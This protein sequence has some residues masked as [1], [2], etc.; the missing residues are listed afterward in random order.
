MPQKES[1]GFGK[2]KEYPVALTPEV[3]RDKMLQ[4][5]ANLQQ[6]ERDSVGRDWILRPVNHTDPIK[7]I[8]VSDLHIGSLAT[9]NDSVLRLVD[10]V[11]SNKNVRVVL[12]GDE[13]EGI[14]AEYLDTNRTPLDLESQIDLLR[15][16]CLEPLAEAGRI[17]AMVSGYW[18]HPGWAQDATT[19]NIW[20]TMTKGLNIPILKNGGEMRYKFA[21]GHIHSIRIR[22]NPPGGNRVDPVSGL[23]M[24]E[25]A[26]SES[27]RTDGAMSGH[28]HTMA[29]AKEWYFGAKASVYYISAGT[30]KGSHEGT[31]ADRYG[32]KLGGKPLCDPLGQGVI[33][34]G[35][36]GKYNSRI[37]Q[38]DKRD[39]PYPSAKHGQV[40]FEAINLLNAAEKQ[41]ITDEMKEKIRAEVEKA[42]KKTYSPETSRLSKTLFEQK[43]AATEKFGKKIVENQY[44]R[45]KM[46]APFDSLTFNIQ[47]KLP[48]TFHLD[49]NARIGSSDDAEIIKRL[50]DHMRLIR[51]NPHSFVVFLRNMI[52][53]EAGKSPERIKILDNFV[54]IINGAREQTLAIMFDE[55]MRKSD[56]KKSLGQEIEDLPVAPASYVASKTGKFLIH[57]L[58]LIKL[59]I[60]P[61]ESIKGKPVYIGAFADK[62]M[63]SGSF[64]QPTFGLK[65]IYN[66]YMQEKPGY[67]A[68]G[69]MPSAGT[70]TFF[71]RSNAETH[72][73]ILIHPG[74]W[75]KY[76]DT[77]GK[78][79]VVPGA[80]P[81]QAIIFMPGERPEDYL[82]YPTVDADETEYME[83]SLMLLKGLEILG[84]KDKVLKKTR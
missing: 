3:R 23:R 12:L 29:T 50:G 75:A 6:I 21:N 17:D 14:K 58:S 67:I 5:I 11:L 52:D 77:M 1:S 39:Y 60:G 43:P 72:Y 8:S 9:N 66:K 44:S 63:G 73:P 81:G 80:Q 32:E 84:L 45:I 48:I 2:Y 83:D 26:L 56:W 82:A 51:E 71:D 27:A 35:E 18:G 37:R 49:Q 15:L 31:P 62:M 79:N 22:H 78:G 41:G 28:I 20:S 10:Y 61:S 38:K 30:E 19:I 36:P 25:L 68:G 33:L 69:H 42:P 53:K 47:T 24:A 16:I 34:Q 4:A 59:A 74:W 76:V 70:M 65:Q 7:V 57:H 64:A 55:S 40:A 13:I 46:Q 54:N